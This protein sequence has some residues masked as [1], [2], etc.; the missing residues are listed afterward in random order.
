MILIWFFRRNIC[1]WVRRQSKSADS[2]LRRLRNSV[3]AAR[4]MHTAIESILAVSR[5][6]RP[7]IEFRS[8]DPWRGTAIRSEWS[9]TPTR[10]FGKT[11]GAFWSQDPTSVQVSAKKFTKP[12][13]MQ[14]LFMFIFHTYFSSICRRE[15]RDIPFIITACVREVEKRGMGEVGL[16]RVSGSA[17]DI[18]KLRK[19]FES[20]S[21]EAEQLLKEVCSIFDKNIK[22]IF[23]LRIYKRLCLVIKN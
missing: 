1:R 15:K 16:Y 11:S 4:K 19:S 5:P 14:H 9:D 2:S 6:Y 17:S 18:A 10:A 8:S 7:G 20:N 12:I 22:F 3:C 23:C 13:Q 21:Y